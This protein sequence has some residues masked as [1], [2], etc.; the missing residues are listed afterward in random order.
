MTYSKL[1]AFLVL[2]MLLQ[3][4]FMAGLAQPS[5]RIAFSSP[6]RRSFA[7]RSANSMQSQTPALFSKATGTHAN[8][9]TF[10]SD[11]RI[12]DDLLLWGTR[13]TREI[14]FPY[15]RRWEPAAGS[16]LVLRLAHSPGLLPRLSYL[17]VE[18][19]GRL[20][21]TIDLDATNLDP[22]DVVVPIG[23]ADLKDY[24]Q[25]VLR[26]GQHYTMEC[27]DPFSSTLWTQVGRESKLVLSAKI[28]NTPL[29][30]QNWPYPL[31]D[32]RAVTRTKLYFSMPEHAS[33]E[34]C[35]ALS[36]VACNLG[37]SPGAR[38]VQLTD[39]QQEATSTIVVGTP[40]ENPLITRLSARL[41]L[42][43]NANGFLDAAGKEIAKDTGVLE[44]IS[45]PV[46]SEKLTLVVTGA[47]PA[48]VLKAV[49]A[50]TNPK[51]NPVV[52]GAYAIVYNSVEPEQGDNQILQSPYY[53]PPGKVF[54]FKQLGQKTTTVHGAGPGYITYEADT[55]PG[56]KLLGPP[57]QMHVVFGYCA[58]ANPDLSTFEVNL[59]DVSIGS[60]PLVKQA[61]QSR[62]SEDVMIPPELIGPRNKFDFIFHLMPKNLGRCMPLNDTHLWGTLYEETSI[63]MDREYLA[64]LPDL[65]LLRYNGF[66]LVQNNSL[67]DIAFVL[68]ASAAD[69]ALPGLANLAF[70]LGKWGSS[71][72]GG[73]GVFY[74]ND[75]PDSVRSSKY[76]ILLC[77]STG[78][79]TI[80]KILSE[81]LSYRHEGIA[82]I[83]QGQHGK[84]TTTDGD[85]M[86][87]IEE[88]L[89][90]W[91]GDKVILVLSSPK[92]Q[93]FKYAVNGIVNEKVRGK[94]TGSLCTISADMGVKGAEIGP[95]KMIGAA[96][97]PWRYAAIFLS[98]QAWLAPVLVMAIVIAA[99]FI[100]RAI[101]D[102]KR[103]SSL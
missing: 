21:K 39:N 47:S 98:S 7:A 82:K 43:M 46:N 94:L 31:V 55:T 81:Q 65:S 1:Q 97:M 57:P 10:G 4:L 48:A 68:P 45:D 24:N 69:P 92:S 54:S 28:R 14:D 53:M 6:A 34:T 29:N 95:Q 78:C 30:L 35:R 22:T 86:G 42:A 44:L 26:Y 103:A 67:K 51:L 87:V 11:L 25:L 62:L 15:P 93:V 12:S 23:I 32:D 99:A 27:E 77:P 64:K 75:L 2:G 63:D 84:L 41:P 76:L 96:I 36:M 50:L 49:T 70:T 9:A 38:T 5:T 89:S 66:P 100:L 19:N 102:R 101:L 79:N 88:T 58:D 91:S 37:S 18:L 71:A 85:A 83:L 60:F 80:E 3:N 90:P 74:D 72:A 13:G 16:S 73:P 56:I 61:G 40:A 8:I 52:N 59:N 20:L 17:A 33:I